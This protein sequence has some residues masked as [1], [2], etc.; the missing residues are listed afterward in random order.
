MAI[1]DQFLKQARRFTPISGEGRQVGVDLSRATATSGN[2]TIPNVPDINVKGAPR[3]PTTPTD[4]R[5]E[6][7]REARARATQRFRS[8]GVPQQG[9][10]IDL[11]GYEKFGQKLGRSLRGTSASD[12]NPFAIDPADTTASA[13]AFK[14]GGFVNKK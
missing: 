1:A 6:A 7:H 2:I 5:V 3:I 10:D 13:Y 11:K 4:T 8:A 12:T 9:I 14:E